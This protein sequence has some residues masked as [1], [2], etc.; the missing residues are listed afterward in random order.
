[1][2]DL[3]LDTAPSESQVPVLAAR[4]ALDEARAFT[5]AAPTDGRRRR[6]LARTL[7]ALGDALKRSGDLT[8]ALTCYREAYDI[9]RAL[10]DANPSERLADMSVCLQQIGNVLTAQGDLAGAAV[11]LRQELDV[12]RQVAELDRDDV[13]KRRDVANSVKRVGD[14]LMLKSILGNF[15]TGG[16]G[17]RVSSNGTGPEDRLSRLK[18]VGDALAARGDLAGALALTR[19]SLEIG[20]SLAAQNPDNETMLRDLSW[21]L[22]AVGK[23]HAAQ[24]DFSAALPVFSEALDIRRALAARDSAD[25]VRQLDLSWSLM[26]IGE[27]LESKGDLAA[28]LAAYGNG[29]TI[30]RDLSA[31]DP[32][33]NGLRCDLATSLIK[34]GD[35][36]SVQGDAEGASAAYREALELARDLSEREPGQQWQ[37]DLS[38]LEERVTTVA[39]KS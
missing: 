15:G 10:A 11:T 1:V 3:R 38:A 32:A 6:N 7:N 22:S 8:A 30:R 16:G 17:G 29:V 4:R 18:T 24:G 20:R 19:E 36:L 35:V 25:A 23:M 21:T 34:M 33:N 12:R 2:V 31:A 26:A 27:V 13:D 14:L 5:D 37:S 9:V 39:P 28:A